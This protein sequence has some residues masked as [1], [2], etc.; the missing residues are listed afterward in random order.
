MPRAQSVTRKFQHQRSHQR[1]SNSLNPIYVR[2]VIRGA[3]QMISSTFVRHLKFADGILDSGF[4]TRGALL[5][6][7]AVG[8]SHLSISQATRPLPIYEMGSKINVA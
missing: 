7:F 1:S 8:A 3:M 4:A 6:A 5:R 2:V